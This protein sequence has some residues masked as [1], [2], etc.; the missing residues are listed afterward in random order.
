MKSV[1]SGSGPIG[2]SAW[3]FGAPSVASSNSRYR[4]VYASPAPPLKLVNAAR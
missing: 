2:A 1:A 4:N 3:I